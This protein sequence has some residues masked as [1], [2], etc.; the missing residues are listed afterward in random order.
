MGLILWRKDVRLYHF[1][2]SD[3]S[4]I[5]DF[6]QEYDGYLERMDSVVQALYC[7]DNETPKEDFEL[8]RS[9]L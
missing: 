9:I 4:T 5:H 2:D 1:S 7:K 3:L 8:N 6:P